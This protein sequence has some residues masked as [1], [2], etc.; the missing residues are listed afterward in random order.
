[1][2]NYKATQRKQA[3]AAVTISTTPK[4]RFQV[5]VNIEL[6]KPFF[7]WDTEADQVL[8]QTDSSAAVRE[9]LA[10]FVALANKYDTEAKSEGQV[11]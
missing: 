4:G 5:R 11:D 2:P 9:T 3:K 8:L 10:A 7:I 6:D 1:M